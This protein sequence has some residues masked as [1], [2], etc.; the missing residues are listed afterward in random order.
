VD[1]DRLVPAMPGQGGY[2]HPPM[3]Q[4][5]E[6]QAMLHGVQLDALP[7]DDHAGHLAAI[8]RFQRS[9]AFAVMSED[10]VILFAMH[11]KQHQEFLM[12][13]QR[14]AQSPVAPGQGNNVPSGMSQGGGTDMDA[15]EGGVQ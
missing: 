13:Q 3:S 11:M 8:E 12:Q 9:E 4:D 10:R 2:Q 14:M 6:N 15:L 1:I 5:S 7:T